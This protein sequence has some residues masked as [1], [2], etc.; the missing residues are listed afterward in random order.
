MTTHAL[1]LALVTLRTHRYRFR[2]WC[3]EHHSSA[4]AC[5]CG[6]HVAACDVAENMIISMIGR[7]IGSQVSA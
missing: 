2:Q 4:R 5:T 3:A 1:Q 7:S 6:Q